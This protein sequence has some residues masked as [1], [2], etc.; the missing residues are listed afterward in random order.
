MPT[1]AAVLSELKKTGNM[2]AMYLAGLVADGSRLTK[3]Q[4]NK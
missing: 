3:I 1:A 2:D 4:L